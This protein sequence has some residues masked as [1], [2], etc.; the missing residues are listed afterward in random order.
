[1]RCSG[2][3]GWLVGSQANDAHVLSQ[4][5]T[6]EWRYEFISSPGFEVLLTAQ[7]YSGNKVHIHVPLSIAESWRHRFL[8]GE[9]II[10]H[11]V[12]S[13]LGHVTDACNVCH[14]LPIHRKVHIYI[15]WFYGPVVSTVDDDLL[16][17]TQGPTD[18]GG[19]FSLG[20]VDL[21]LC[22]DL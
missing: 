21:R 3:S 17:S 8:T 12:A 11:V 13:C 16:V 18:C 22:Q 14:L 7:L 15:W 4:V 19:W 20:L 9:S 2:P 1:M 10:Q 5:T 6:P